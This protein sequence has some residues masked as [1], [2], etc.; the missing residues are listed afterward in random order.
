MIIYLRSVGY[1]NIKQEV[2]NQRLYF[3]FESLQ[4]IFDQYIKLTNLLKTEKQ[5]PND[6]YY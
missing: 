6:P 3:I 2:L 4:D 1:Y 5:Q